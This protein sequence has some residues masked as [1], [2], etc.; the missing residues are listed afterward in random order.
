MMQRGFITEYQMAKAKLRDKRTGEVIPVFSSD[1]LPR[2]PYMHPIWLDDNGNEYCEVNAPE[3]L[4]ERLS[5][6]IIPE[7]VETK[8]LIGSRVKAAREAKGWTRERLAREL[9]LLTGKAVRGNNVADVE[10]ARTAYTIDFLINIY[11]LLDK[12]IYALY[13]NL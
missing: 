1:T 6:E 3:S 4:M 9:T 12:Y 11:F 13:R 5:Y 10:E 7:P 2:S 8:R